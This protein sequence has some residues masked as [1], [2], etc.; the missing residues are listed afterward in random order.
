MNMFKGLY[1]S[2]FD[3]ELQTC[4]IVFWFMKVPKKINALSIKL[5][6]SIFKRELVRV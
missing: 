2:S 1:F 6:L 3:V 4:V 5:E